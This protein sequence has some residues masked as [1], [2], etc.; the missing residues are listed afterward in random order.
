M[1]AF[2]D[3]YFDGPGWMIA[4]F[5]F[6]VLG[7]FIGKKTIIWFFLVYFPLAAILLYFRWHLK[8]P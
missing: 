3:W 5:V 7:F 6:G 4:C 8:Q 2:T 1:K